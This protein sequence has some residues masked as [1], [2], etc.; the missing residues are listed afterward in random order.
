MKL[1]KQGIIEMRQ[2]K[3]NNNRF[4]IL[5]YPF[6]L[7][8]LVLLIASSIKSTAQGD[9][10]VF[11]KRIVFDE[12]KKSQSI[13]ISNTGRDTARYII[14]F[15]QIRMKEDGSFENITQPDPNQYFADPYLRIFPRQV[16]LGPNEAQVVKIQLQKTDQMVPGEY[17]SHLYF[18]A[19]PDVKPLGE[20]EIQRDTSSF[21]VKLTPV[22]GIT[23]PIIIRKGETT[24]KVSLSNI[25]FQKTYDSIPVLKLDFNR[26]GNI[27]VYGDITVNL[28]LPN[29][30][31]IK[32]GE[33]DGFAVYTPGM[34][35]N[36]K[37]ELKKGVDY[38]KGKLLIT[39]ATSVEDKDSKLAEAELELH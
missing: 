12:T 36:C 13:N 37:I 24:A 29:G 16:I 19:M 6:I 5:H 3:M 26:I 8:L 33:I 39:Y 20:K 27:S 15:V 22:F 35:R 32:V 4:F 10:L 1:K 23:I 21:S 38:K 25:S 11:P 34:I 31:T 2:F 17:R 18:R 30:K 14:S 7:I 9:L 28:I